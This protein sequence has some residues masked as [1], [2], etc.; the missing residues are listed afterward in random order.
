MQLSC[1][2]RMF[3]FISK[4]H[5]HEIAKEGLLILL[6]KTVMTTDQTIVTYYIWIFL[7]SVEYAFVR[8]LSQNKCFYISF[9]FFQAR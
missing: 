7:I 9:K 6:K 8:V 3:L 1:K 2:S 5:A 4:T